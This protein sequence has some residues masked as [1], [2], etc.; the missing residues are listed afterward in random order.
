MTDL[1]LPL[2]DPGCVMILQYDQEPEPMVEVPRQAIS[3][4]VRSHYWPA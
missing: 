3:R 4:L 1:P 2:D